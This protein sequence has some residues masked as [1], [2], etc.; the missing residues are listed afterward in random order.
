MKVM[1]RPAVRWY[2]S[3]YFRIGFSFVV[4]VVGVLVAQSVVFNLML[5]RPRFPGRSPNALAAIVAADL[6]SAMAQDPVLDVDD[7]LKRE[8]ARLSP[9]YAVMKSGSV[10]SNRSTPP[11]RADIVRSAQ[12]VLAG[13]D[14]RRT[15]TERTIGGPPF[16]MAPI[17]TAGELRG[18]VVLPP[19]V[20]PNAISRDV[21][22]LLTVPGTAL[23]VT[24]TIL[25][26]AF[27][28]APAR[29]RLKL[30]QDATLRLGAG[31]L[32]AR[33]PESGGDEIADVA[34][35]FNRMATELMAR[36]EALR[37]SDRLRRQML[38]D[39]SHELKT[40]LAAMRGYVETLHMSDVA[41]DPAT[42]ERYFAT[43]ERETSRLDRIVKDLLDLARLENGV[44][45]LDVRMF[46]IGRV[47]DHVAERHEPDATARRVR[48]RTHVADAADQIVADPDRIEQVIENLFANA[49][50]HTPDG[51]TVELTA[52]VADDYV[53]M[54]VIDSGAGIPP[55]HIA[56]VFE[57]FYKVDTARTS[58]SDG[59]GLGL[60]IAKAIVE[61]HDGTIEVD[62][63]PGRTVFTIR[64]PKAAAHAASANLYPTPHAVRISSGS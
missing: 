2:R 18:V 24:G 54:S 27:I 20:L 3:F 49:L 19:P 4:F 47:F 11:L 10:A 50:R 7:Y 42:R 45:E 58:G 52:D 39:V 6:G 44:G 16:V 9:L 51:G 12:G 17:Q 59:S 8:Y 1:T 64:L 55:A 41:L 57:R 33:A 40:P 25:A 53:V 14:F 46:A 28:F 22:R 13:T 21:G 30:L 62:S 31:D 15:G 63:R 32:S 43:L 38:A 34:A 5:T 23:L 36:D 29:R 61:R 26:A 35:T 60:S 48:I 37:A 56:Q